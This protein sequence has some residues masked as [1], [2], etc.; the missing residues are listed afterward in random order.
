MVIKMNP[1]KSLP[2]QFL[3]VISILTSLFTHAQTQ[4]SHTEIALNFGVDHLVTTPNS[5][6]FLTGTPGLTRYQKDS[7]FTDMTPAD[8]KYI[9]GAAFNSLGDLYFADVANERVVKFNVKTGEQKIIAIGLAR[10]AGLAINSKDEVFVSLFDF[11][12]GNSV[13]KISDQ[14]DVELFAEGGYL[15]GPIGLVFDE[16]NNLYAGNWNDGVI[17]RI[18]TN[19]TQSIIARLPNSDNSGINQITYSNGFIYTTSGEVRHL[20]QIDLASKQHSLVSLP[21]TLDAIPTE[22]IKWKGAITTSN[23][24]KSLYI[25]S[26]SLGLVKISL[27][28]Y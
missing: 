7:G 20:Y 25:T 24:G 5:T 9:V 15:N 19:G 18:T 10:P 6:I 3:L 8:V 16:Y 21:S 23:N 4:Q 26:E 2:T 11:G 17:T 13:A 1:V 14:G 28:S 27:A 22:K 12:K